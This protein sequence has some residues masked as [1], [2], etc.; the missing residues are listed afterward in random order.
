MIRSAGFLVEIQERTL[1]SRKM[2]FSS[3]ED[4][5]V[6]TTYVTVTCN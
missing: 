5:I 4:R 1:N 3:R 6:E 2:W